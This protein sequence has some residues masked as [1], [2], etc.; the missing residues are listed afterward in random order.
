MPLSGPALPIA[1]Y[2]MNAGTAARDLIT[3]IG[4]QV[5]LGGAG[6]DILGDKQHQ[7]RMA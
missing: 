7:V 4:A 3:G 6:D 5:A 2:G 1:N